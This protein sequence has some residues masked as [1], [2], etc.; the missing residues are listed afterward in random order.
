MARILAALLASLTTVT[1]A[2]ADEAWFDGAWVIDREH[3]LELWTHDMSPHARELFSERME[4]IWDENA[5]R[6][7]V[8]SHGIIHAHLGNGSI[9]EHAYSI[10]PMRNDQFELVVQTEDLAS[11]LVKRTETGFCWK[12][13][14]YYVPE[15]RSMAERFDTECFIRDGA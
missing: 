12:I 9:A 2:F 14:P 3:T 6:R 15:S 13:E 10:R 1:G 7:V 11:V 8:I 4:Q 5:S